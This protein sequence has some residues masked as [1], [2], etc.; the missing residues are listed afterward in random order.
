MTSALHPKTRDEHLFTDG[1]K[2]ILALDGGGVRG[3]MTCGILQQM[4]D[5]LKAR[6]PTEVERENFRLCHY[7]DLVAGTST[8]AIMATL[9]ALGFTVAEMKALY[10]QLAKR[11][12]RRGILRGVFQPVFDSA[13]LTNVINE[14]FAEYKRANHIPTQT[15]LQLGSEY[16]RTGLLI[17]SKRVDTGSPWILTNN[18][19]SK[20]WEWD[21]PLWKGYYATHGGP[22]FDFD[23]NKHYELG[24]VVQASASAPF[25]LSPVYK[26]IS[27]KE[28]GVFF[29]GGVSPH[30]NPAMQAF[31]MATAKWN[32]EAP[33]WQGWAGDPP[34][35]WGFGWK[36]GAD[37]ISVIS[38]GTGAFRPRFTVEEVQKQWAPMKALSALRGMIPDCS[39][40]G[41]TWMQAMSRPPYPYPI[42]SEID[43][44][45][46]LT[47]APDPLLHFQRIDV[48]LQV[49]ALK[50]LMGEDV[51]ADMCSGHDKEGPE[52]MVEDLKELANSA[53]TNMNRLELIGDRLG[54]Y[55]FGK[56][57]KG[58]LPMAAD[59]SKP[60][61]P[62]ELIL[63]RRFDV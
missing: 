13:Q 54:E 37:N 33:P 25:Y 10:R 19:K 24:T 63:P 32:H 29:D 18:P 45:N 15:P 38:L 30:N 20:F 22:H 51:F 23:S 27:E 36:T 46:G 1:P 2:R 12:F 43:A 47:V 21:S 17:C 7:F 4:E 61:D 49:E 55:W 58:R 53:D 50:E 3:I 26:K 34:S 52:G 56:D 8:G 28:E 39:T 41:I 6:L 44:M 62:S 9:I 42:N 31:L 40:N 48:D 59:G 11:V 35:P 5:A 16:L 57:G 14:T 60:Q